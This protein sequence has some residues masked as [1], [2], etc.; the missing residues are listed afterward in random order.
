MM[1]P[2]V[3]VITLISIKLSSAETSP[4][5]KQITKWHNNQVHMRTYLKY[6][7]LFAWVDKR[8]W[9]LWFVWESCSWFLLAFLHLKTLC[10]IYLVIHLNW[11]RVWVCASCAIP[12]R[13]SVK[14]SYE[15]QRVYRWHLQIPALAWEK[16]IKDS[17]KIIKTSERDPA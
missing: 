2:S 1:L 8:A 17:V 5:G 4:S 14:K 15:L 6:R 9:I 11:E 7:R 12:T 10:A 16:I 3:F 13:E